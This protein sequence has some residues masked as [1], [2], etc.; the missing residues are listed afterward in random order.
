MSAFSS[1]GNALKDDHDVTGHVPTWRTLCEELEFGIVVCSRNLRAAHKG[2]RGMN[3]QRHFLLLVTLA[4]AAAAPALGQAVAPT[5]G[6]ARSGTQ[7]VAAIPDFS[8]M[9]GHPYIPSFDPPVSGPGPVMNKSRW[10]Q[11][12]GTDGPLAP[13]ANAVLVSNP[14]K[15]VGDYTNPILKPH[16]AEAVKKHGEIELSGAAAPVPSA[17]CWPEP[18]P[19]IFSANM[20][21]LMIQQPD[22]ITI[23][24]DENDEVRHVRMNQP[25]PVHVTPSWYG[26]SVGRYE[27][28]TLVIDTIGIKADRPFAMIDQFG[29]PYTEALHVVE[30]YR[31]IDYQDAKE[32]QERGAKEN[33]RIPGPAF[34]WAPAPNYQGKGMQIAVHRRR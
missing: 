31:L 20:G 29:T 7:S 1:T 25:H 23:L 12:F 19:Y 22:K 5:A 13:G 27:G 17:Q 6:P 34:G 30:R 28:D 14:N 33:W 4:A 18:I 16:A 10:S 9:W 11:I 15:L 8:G 26:D 21:I 2:E 24:Y 32:A 3:G